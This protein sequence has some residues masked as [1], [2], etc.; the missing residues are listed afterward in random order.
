MVG[1]GREMET[2]VLEKQLKRKKINEEKS[3]KIRL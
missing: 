1:E 2:T 3:E